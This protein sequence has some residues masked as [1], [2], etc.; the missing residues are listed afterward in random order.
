MPSEMHAGWFLQSF[1]SKGDPYPL[2][3]KV[4]HNSIEEE[5]KNLWRTTSEEPFCFTKG[6]FVVK[7]GSSDYKKVSKRWFFKEPLSEWFF[8]EPKMVF[9]DIAVKN[10]LSTFILK[11][12]LK[13]SVDISFLTHIAPNQTFCFLNMTVVIQACIY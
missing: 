10:L 2:K 6:F 7:E 9:Y 12:L 8:V 11:S 5:P 4:L 1:I 3:N 13:M